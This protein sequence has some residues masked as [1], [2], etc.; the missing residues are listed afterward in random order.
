[1][2][3]EDWLIFSNAENGLIFCKTENGLRRGPNGDT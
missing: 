2:I 3:A 1:M